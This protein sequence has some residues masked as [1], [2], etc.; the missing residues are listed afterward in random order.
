MKNQKGMSHIM[1][2][3]SIIIIAIIIAL[4]VILINKN[5]EKGNIDNYQTDMLLIQGKIKVISQEAT[6]Q[7]KDELLKGRKIEENL[8]DEQIKKLLENKIISKEETSFSMY[9][10]LDKS[11]LEEMG[12]QSLKLKE[13]YYLVNYNTDEIIYCKG[14]EI[15]NNIYYKLSELKQLNVY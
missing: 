5:I 4:I 15:N 7:E 13:G 8:E 14:I 9:Y 10:I 12:L 3:I 11:N 6:I 1:L 2:I